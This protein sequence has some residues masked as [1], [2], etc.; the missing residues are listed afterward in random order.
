MKT[1]FGRVVGVGLLIGFI[2]AG[3]LY[4]QQPEQAPPPVAPGAAARYQLFGRERDELILI[5]TASG[6]CWIYQ[7]YDDRKKR[8]AWVDLE[9]PPSRK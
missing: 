9:T 7:G 4:A 1:W 5:D 2:V 3:A 6:K 8:P